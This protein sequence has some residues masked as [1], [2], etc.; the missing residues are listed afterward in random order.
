MKSFLLLDGNDVGL[1]LVGGLVVAGWNNSSMPAR[2]LSYVSIWCLAL[3]SY[4]LFFLA[5]QQGQGLLLN[6]DFTASALG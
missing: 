1:V 4:H 3:V 5:R 2:P 6:L